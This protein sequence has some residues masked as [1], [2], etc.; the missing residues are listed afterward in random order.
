M[1]P[2]SYKVGSPK[3][4]LSRYRYIQGHLGRMDTTNASM[5]HCGLKYS[6]PSGSAQSI[7]HRPSSISG[8]NSTITSGRIRPLSAGRCMV[9]PDI[10]PSSYKP[11]TTLQPSCFWLKMKA[12]QASR[13]PWCPCH[14]V[15][16]LVFCSRNS[17]VI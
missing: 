16:L 15:V 1:S 2:S 4:A 11:S 5:A 17:I 6:M 3:Q 12:A 9:P 10:P 14:W 13:C 8:S 7:R